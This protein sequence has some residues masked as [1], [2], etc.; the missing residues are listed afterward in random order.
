MKFILSS[1]LLFLC[2]SAPS[3]AVNLVLTKTSLGK[4]KLS[5]N[6]MISFKKIKEAFPQFI[7]EH[8]IASGDSPDFHYITVQN[9]HKELLFYLIS[10]FDEKVNK[11]TIKYDIDLLKITSSKIVDSYGIRVGDRVSKVVKIRGSNLNIGA[12]HFDNAIGKDKTF[13]Q[14]TVEPS[15]ALKKK[16]LDYINPE[17][18][19]LDQI[20]KKNPE[21]TS[22]S[23][24]YPSWD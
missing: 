4:L 17:E 19:T 14:V 15:E 16:G 18:V 5:Q 8:E 2:F 12:N 7:V 10:Y 6:S 1:A 3:L 24:P 22:I 21:V 11:D 20:L 13:Y 23:W 9:K